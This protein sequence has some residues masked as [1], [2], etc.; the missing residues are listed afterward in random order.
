MNQPT[1]QLIK[2]YEFALIFANRLHQKQIRK[3]NSTPYFAHLLSVSA[4][5]LEDDGSQ[6]KAI[7]ALLHDSI[8]D[9]GGKKTAD[10]I[11]QIFGD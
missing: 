7:A 9:R 10:L 4:L 3:I 11:R 8:E 2:K 5:V 6:N 1:T